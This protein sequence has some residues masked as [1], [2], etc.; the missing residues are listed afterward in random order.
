MDYSTASMKITSALLSL[1]YGERIVNKCT[2]YIIKLI[3]LLI[4]KYYVDVSGIYNNKQETF[5]I[6]I[7]CSWTDWCFLKVGRQL[8]FV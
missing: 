8:D 4:R 6:C 2:V 1:P 7:L 3:S 5:Y